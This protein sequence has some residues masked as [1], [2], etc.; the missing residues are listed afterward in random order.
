MFDIATPEQKLPRLVHVR[1]NQTWQSQIRVAAFAAYP[2]DFGVSFDRGRGAR[3]LAR[4]WVLDDP[5]WIADSVRR[6]ADCAAMAPT[7][8]SLVGSPPPGQ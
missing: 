1:K 5:A 4:A 8:G 7:S 2:V 6:S 3:I